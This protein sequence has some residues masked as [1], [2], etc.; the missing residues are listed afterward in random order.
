[1]YD[2]AGIGVGFAA[3]HVP[4]VRSLVAGSVDPLKQGDILISPDTQNFL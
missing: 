3:I 2:T 4:T 1:M